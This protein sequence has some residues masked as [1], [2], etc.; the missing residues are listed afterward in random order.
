MNHLVRFQDYDR[1]SIVRELE[2]GS[3][4]VQSIW[5]DLSGTL[6]QEDSVWTNWHC[7]GWPT[8]QLKNSLGG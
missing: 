8:D 2:R 6:F 4:T 5:S 3:F 7:P 1:D